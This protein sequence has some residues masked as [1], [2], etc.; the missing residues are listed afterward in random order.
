MFRTITDKIQRDKDYPDRTFTIDILSR[1]REGC[2]YEHLTNP[3]HCEVNDAKEY[4]PVRERRPSVRHNICRLV[5]DDAVA[6]LFSEGHF[7]TPEVEDENDRNTLRTIAKDGRLNDIMIEAATVGS[8]GSVAI[9]MRVLK[10]KDKSHRLFFCVHDTRFLI[11]EF[12][13]EAPDTLDRMTE[14]YKVLGSDLK[15]LGYTISTDDLKATFWFHREWDEQNETW[16]L[17]YKQIDVDQAERNGDSFQLT[18]DKD[19]SIDHKLGFVPWVWIKNLPGKLRLVNWSGAPT[20]SDIDGACT[21]Q[22]AIETMIEIDYTLSQGGRGL[23]YSMDPQLVL[24]E[25]SSS[26]ERQLIK[27]PSNAIVMDADGDANLL[28]ITGSAFAVVLEWV[29]ALREFALE[30]VHG[31]RADGQKLSTAQSGRAMEL[32]NQALIW[33]A[34]KMRISYGEYAYRELLLMACNA[35]AL[36]P[37]SVDGEQL[38]PMKDNQKIAL[39]WPAWYAKT[40]HDLQEEAITIKTLREAKAISKATAVKNIAFSYDIEDVEKELAD[41]MADAK[42]DIALIGE[43]NVQGQVRINE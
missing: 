30:S 12:K 33:L 11:P 17:P 43:G 18:K 31:N 32:M 28:E 16:F 20:Y 15:K 41:I 6:L 27:G 39:N 37:L 9:H 22:A 21:F 38:P 26:G 29:R 3:F 7:P 2:I 1:V 40:P 14:K 24:K 23:K 13:P 36:Y 8:V 25:P 42:E 34:D 10:Q 35:H 5:V 4:I 19:K